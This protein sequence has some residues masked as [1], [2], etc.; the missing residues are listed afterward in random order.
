VCLLPLSYSPFD[1]PDLADSAS[2][3][4]NSNYVETKQIFTSRERQFT[5]SLAP[6]PRQRYKSENFGDAAIDKLGSSGGAK[7][8]RTGF[9]SVGS[10]EALRQAYTPWGSYRDTGNQGKS[11]Q[12]KRLSFSNPFD[13][14]KMHSEAPAFRRRW[15]HVFPTN[16]RGVAFQTHHA[17]A[18]EC[19]LEG[20]TSTL[21]NVE[22]V[23]STP[24]SSIKRKGILKHTLTSDSGL[25]SDS[26]SGS[27]K[28]ESFMKT[29]TSTGLKLSPVNLSPR[30]EDRNLWKSTKK[31]KG[32]PSLNRSSI[33]GQDKPTLKHSAHMPTSSSV[34]PES[35]RRQ[36]E[37]WN[38]PFLSSD[39]ENFASVRRT[40]VDWM[41]LVEP[42]HLPIT[43][44]FYPAKEILD[45]DY[46]QYNTN[47]V[48]FR[49]EQDQNFMETSSEKK[50]PEW[51][52]DHSTMNTFQAFLEMIS[53]R[54][55]QVIHV[56]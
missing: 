35:M 21:Q 54:L 46:A 44:D 26:R 23:C 18:Q 6:P 9:V 55:S 43:T 14:N 2:T 51:Y 3:S 12:K 24:Q 30:D 10:A 11:L 8:D 48:V 38:N 45:R 15:V 42:A 33:T 13:P 40:G 52:S 27:F 41:S 49:E 47:L 7:R 29:P 16:K 37:R 19:E 1:G 50:V 4:P 32:S 56:G 39:T 31:Q 34:T 25:A 20:S 28:N 5:R 53:Q 17:A 22:S 36:H